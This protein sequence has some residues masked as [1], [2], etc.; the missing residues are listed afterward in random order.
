MTS[1]GRIIGVIAIIRMLAPWS[2]ARPPNT[3]LRF[4]VTPTHI[5]QKLGERMFDNGT[6]SFQAT[7]TNV[8]RDAIRVDAS[9]QHNVSVALV[10]N[11]SP[12]ESQTTPYDA[13]VEIVHPEV[14]LKPKESAVFTIPGVYN[15]AANHK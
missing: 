15:F 10:C 5:R 14:T 8:S 6:I 3:V 12:A 13:V 7:L 11:G 9:F 2:I 1:Q 4:D